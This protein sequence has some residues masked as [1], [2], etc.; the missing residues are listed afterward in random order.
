MKEWWSAQNGVNGQRE[1]ME[2]WDPA[3]EAQADQEVWR[4]QLMAGSRR[5]ELQRA[6]AAAARAQALART[7]RERYAASELAWRI[8]ADRGDPGAELAAAQLLVRLDPHDPVSMLALRHA[9][10]ASGRRRS[11]RETGAR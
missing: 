1:A 9:V 8:A 7:P 11:A 2:S 6:A 5:H 10:R 3:V 4:R